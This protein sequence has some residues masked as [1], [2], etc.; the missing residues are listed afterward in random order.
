MGGQIDAEEPEAAIHG[1]GELTGA[2]D[3]VVWGS[4]F[5]V[6]GHQQEVQ[7]MAR[8]QGHERTVATLLIGPEALGVYDGGTMCSYDPFRLD[9]R[10][11]PEP[12]PG[13]LPPALR[14]VEDDDLLHR[15]RFP[16]WIRIGA[17]L[18]AFG[19][20]CSLAL[21]GTG[22]SLLTHPALPLVTR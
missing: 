4:A 6:I 11:E 18:M 1:H 21:S 9:F 2:L 12:V 13:E 5:R 7:A 17:V 16:L 19:F 3:E 22:P 15:P 20:F 14:V 8:S 10:P